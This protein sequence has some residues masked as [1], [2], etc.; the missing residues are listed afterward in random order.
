MAKERKK[1]WTVL[2]FG[3]AVAVG[4]YLLGLLLAALLLVKGHVPETAILPITGFW[5]GFA[6]LCGALTAVRRSPWGTLTGGLA[7]AVVF[8]F[9]LLVVGMSFWQ[10]ITWTGQGGIVMLCALAGGIMAGL[11]GGRKQKRKKRKGYKS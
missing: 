6:V 11:M 5:C 10:E 3:D 7:A 2:L 4:L 9:F 1:N 8:I